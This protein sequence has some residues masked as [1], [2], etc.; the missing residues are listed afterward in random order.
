MKKRP[1]KASKKARKRLERLRKRVLRKKVGLSDEK[2][3]KVVEVLRAGT[4]ERAE[5]RQKA[6][7]ARR[8]IGRLLQ[9]DSQDQITPRW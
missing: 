8:A 2:I 6:R 7:E 4:R 3:K 1:K 5:A 9:S